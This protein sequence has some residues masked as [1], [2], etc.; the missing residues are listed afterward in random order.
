MACTIV[1]GSM[2][3]RQ[4]VT[5]HR[6]ELNTFAYVGGQVYCGSFHV[7]GGSIFYGDPGLFFSEN[8]QLSL[9]S[10]RE[11]MFALRPV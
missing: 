10:S 2:L 4:L 6:L 3:V 11:E 7:S 8:P 5:S 1:R 9:L